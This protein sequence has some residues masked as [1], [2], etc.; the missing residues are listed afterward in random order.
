MIELPT[1]S[2]SA[3]GKYIELGART[4]LKPK[5]ELISFAS[6]V[7][8]GGFIRRFIWTTLEYRVLDNLG[9][10]ISARVQDGEGDAVIYAMR[11]HF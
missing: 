7:D 5:L 3:V 10:N 11:Y 4:V 6:Y 9:L 2:V 8:A 1:L